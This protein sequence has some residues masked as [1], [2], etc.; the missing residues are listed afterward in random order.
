MRLQ[1]PD[2]PAGFTMIELMITL[3]VLGVL[4][5][6]AAPAMMTL[7]QTQQVRTAASDLHGALNFARSE[8]LKRGVSV[9]VAPIAGDWKKGWQ[10]QLPDGSLLR[11]WPALS[12][13]L[14]SISTA[15]IT[16]RSDGHTASAPPAMVVRSATNTQVVARCVSADLS[17][18][19]SLITDSDGNPSNGCQPQ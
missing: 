12:P 13:N 14:A 2:A 6:L 8:A 15:T 4:A 11:S 1:F 10:V 17:G 19:P 5:V 16:Y 9:D 18:R 7:I 3:V